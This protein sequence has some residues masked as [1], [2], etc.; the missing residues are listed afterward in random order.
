MVQTTQIDERIEQIGLM[1]VA[2]L[3][4]AQICRALGITDH[5]LYKCIEREN[6]RIETV[7]KK[8]RLAP[9]APKVG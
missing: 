9:R 2:G 3:T 8:R 5:A 1:L 7:S 6:L 4:N